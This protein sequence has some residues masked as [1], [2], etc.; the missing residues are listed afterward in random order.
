MFT[1]RLPTPIPWTTHRRNTKLRSKHPLNYPLNYRPQG[2]LGEGGGLEGRGFQKP[3]HK[4]SVHTCSECQRSSCCQLSSLVFTS[5]ANCIS[6]TRSTETKNEIIFLFL[7]IQFSFPIQEQLYFLLIT[8]AAI[9][10]H[11]QDTVLETKLLCQS[12]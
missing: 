5:K 12:S 10:K 1:N 8:I 6:Q 9:C 2:F 4:N 3:E 11:Q 7:I